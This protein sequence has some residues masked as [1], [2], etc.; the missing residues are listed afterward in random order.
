M[1]QYIVVFVG[2]FVGRFVLFFRDASK[3]FKPETKTDR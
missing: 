2:R 1:T 3:K